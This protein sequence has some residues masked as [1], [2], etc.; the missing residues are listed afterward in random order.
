MSAVPRP[1]TTDEMI[2]QLW[3]AVIGSNGDGIASRMRR[4]E[5]KVIKLEASDIEYQLQRAASCPNLE[6]L[7][8][9]TH[10]VSE[11]EAKPGKI[12]LKVVTYVGATLGGGL[13]ALLL[14]ILPGVKVSVSQVLQTTLGG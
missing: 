10:K 6:Q 7:Q 12:A 11:L 4:V 3:F 13:L 1:E 9:V 14:D 8:K 2:H 5:D